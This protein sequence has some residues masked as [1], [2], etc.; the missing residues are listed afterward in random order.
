[1]TGK[2]FGTLKP[3]QSAQDRQ[4]LLEQLREYAKTRSLTLLGQLEITLPSLMENWEAEQKEITRILFEDLLA[5][6]MELAE[7][8]LFSRILCLSEIKTTSAQL[9]IARVNGSV[10]FFVELVSWL[11]S[12]GWFNRRHHTVVNRW[13]RDNREQHPFA[14]EFI[15]GRLEVQAE[16]PNG[17]LPKQE[18]DED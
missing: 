14:C 16:F 11:V 2:M 5:R 15:E 4:T 7:C 6:R 8:A 10:P 12:K 9:E 13:L 17:T 1:M 3:V 18:D